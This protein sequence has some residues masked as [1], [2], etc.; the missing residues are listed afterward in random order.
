MAETWHVFHRKG[1]ALHPSDNG[2]SDLV[3]G[4][5]PLLDVQVRVRVPGEGGSHKR[6]HAI[7]RK[8]VPY[9]VNKN[10]NGIKN[11]SDLFFVLR[12]ESG[13]FRRIEYSRVDKRTG[14]PY[15]RVAMRYHT[16][17]AA[18]T[19]GRRTDRDLL[20]MLKVLDAMLSEQPEMDGKVWVQEDVRFMIRDLELL[21]REKQT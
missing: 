4:L 11:A 21:L 16:L 14:R 1:A 15:Q 10:A 9:F 5:S 6:F 12:A 7:L 18:C 19:L 3:E 20:R 17:S 8:C 13:L 2:A